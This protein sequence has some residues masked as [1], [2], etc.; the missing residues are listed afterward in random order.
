[1]IDSLTEFVRGDVLE[2]DNAYHC[3]KCDKKVR[4]VK[5]LTIKSLPDTLVIQLK[6]FEFDWERNE[7]LKFN[8]YFEFP[9]NVDMRP[10]TTEAMNAK[11]NSDSEST[12]PGVDGIPNNFI[13]LSHSVADFENYIYHL[14]GVVVH[15]GQATGG[16]YFSYIKADGSNQWY[17]FDDTEVTQYSCEPQDVKL[18]WYPLFF[19]IRQR[20]LLGSERSRTAGSS[21][22]AVPVSGG[23]PSSCST[24]RTLE[25]S[26]SIAS[27]SR[28]SPWL[29][30]SPCAIR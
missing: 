26:P 30:M 14:K 25:Q 6:R 20:R 11:D 22:A 17:K 13:K 2:N 27:F 4:A 15:S 8:D 24:R 7:P 19:S 3:E 28:H 1:M 5:R 12:S 21:A 16:H 18:K 23:M 10:Y 29:R 9:F